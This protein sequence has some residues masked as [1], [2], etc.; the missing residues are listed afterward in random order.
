MR[1]LL[2]PQMTSARSSLELVDEVKGKIKDD[3][4]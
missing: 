1:K 2:Q 3:P 4:V